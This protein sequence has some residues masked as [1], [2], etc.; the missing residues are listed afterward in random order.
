MAALTVGIIG[1]VLVLI[2]YTLNQLGRLSDE[3]VVYDGLNFAG[4]LLLMVYAFSIEGW[5]F[6][7]LNLV[8]GTVA[9]RDLYLRFKPKEK[10]VA[11]KAEA[12]AEVEEK[13][14]EDK[15]A[16]PEPPKEVPAEEETELTERRP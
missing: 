8:W 13:Q 6:L 4:A 12:K 9:G 15:P 16:E 5:P 11:A 10:P 7:F 1:M 14:E 2:A 3:H